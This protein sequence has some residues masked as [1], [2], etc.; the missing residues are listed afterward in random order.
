MLSGLD[1]VLG[2]DRGVLD[3]GGDH[4]GDADHGPHALGLVGVM[5]L[6]RLGDARREPPSAG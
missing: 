3:V 1:Q 6:D 5:A 2:A 4:V